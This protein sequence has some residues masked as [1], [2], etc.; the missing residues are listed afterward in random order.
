LAGWAAAL[1]L[2]AL[3]AYHSSPSP[4]FQAVGEIARTAQPPERFALSAHTIYRPFLDGVDPRLE[5]L[6]G[7]RP[8]ATLPRLMDY[9]REGGGK[10]VL[11]LSEPR[12]TDL[13]S[14]DPRARVSLGRWRW[15]F[16]ADHFLAGARPNDVELWRLAPPG[17]FAGEGFLLSLE[18]GRP[19][20]LPR[21]LERRAFLRA[22]SE[23]TFLLL[24]GEPSGPAA[25]HTLELS[26]AGETLLEHGCGEPLLRGFLLPG[27]AGE[28]RYLELLGRTRRGGAAEGAPF[29]LRGLDYAGRPDAGFVHGPGWF[30][31]ETDEAHVPFRWSS[32]RTRSL[33]H[34]P[35]GGARLVVEGTAPVE[36]VGAGGRLRVFVDGQPLLQRALLERGYRLDLELPPPNGSPFVE[37]SIES[38]RAFVPDDHQ[39]NGDRR[40]LGLRVYTFRVTPR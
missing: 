20:E 8:G 5:R 6:F 19:S 28:G 26:L 10:Q 34:V 14:V 37:V 9:W 17:F 36:Y 23:P 31:P 38:E 3:S 32:A 2:P 15:P 25:Q 27:R 22:S 4:A 18:A 35:P 39:R 11:F 29:A 40:R 16:D 7:A 13:E 12:R 21:L 24:A 33:V 1:T 30:Y